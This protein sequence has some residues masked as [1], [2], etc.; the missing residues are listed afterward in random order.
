[1]QA[2]EIIFVSPANSRSFDSVN[3]L[4]S[5]S[6]HSA[7][8]DRVRAGSNLETFRA[9]VRAGQRLAAIHVQYEQQLEYPLIKKEKEGEKL[10]Y[11]VES[12]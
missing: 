3:A 10:D 6:I 7:Q 11:H 4:A 12:A 1:V 2:A 9:F 8:D 5:E